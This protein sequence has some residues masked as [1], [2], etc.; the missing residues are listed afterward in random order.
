MN[1]TPFIIE[2]LLKNGAEIFSASLGGFLLWKIKDRI[3]VDMVAT[4][5]PRLF[6]ACFVSLI[7]RFNRFLERKKKSK[8]L[9]KTWE[10]AESSIIQCLRRAIEILES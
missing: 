4:M 7:E 3:L 10:M 9:P 8:K 2:F 5:A 1:L 6:E